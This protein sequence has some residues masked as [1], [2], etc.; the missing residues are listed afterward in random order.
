MLYLGGTN[1]DIYFK[2]DKKRGGPRTCQEIR[3]WFEKEIKSSNI[4]KLSKQTG[5]ML[6]FKFQKPAIFA[7]GKDL[8]QC[9]GFA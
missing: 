3:I 7:I 2:C 8:G 4:I 9:L 5:G 6:T 1:G